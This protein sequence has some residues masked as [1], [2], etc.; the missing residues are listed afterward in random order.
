MDL[1]LITMF[2][3][4]FQ[5]VSSICEL[6]VRIVPS[7]VPNLRLCSFKKCDKRALA[8]GYDRAIGKYHLRFKRGG[9]SGIGVRMGFFGSGFRSFFCFQYQGCVE[10]C[11]LYD[12]R[13]IMCCFLFWFIYFFFFNFCLVLNGVP[14]LHIS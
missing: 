12:K 14:S 6:C 11:C 9:Q 5:I 10:D 7:T 2:L 4:W 3:N 8:K 13:G 1:N